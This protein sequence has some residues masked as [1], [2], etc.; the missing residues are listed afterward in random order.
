MLPTTVPVSCCIAP[1]PVPTKLPATIEFFR[2]ML[3]LT[4]LMAPPVPL[5]LVS[6]SARL[7]VMVTLV[8]ATT[9]VPL[10]L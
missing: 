9:D 8:R 7:P 3:L 10:L 6:L 1:L 5:P 4:L 2:V